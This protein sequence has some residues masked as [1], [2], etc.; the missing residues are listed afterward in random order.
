MKDVERIEDI[1]NIE[2]HIDKL[3]SLKAYVKGDNTQIW[4]Y[5][6]ACEPFITLEIISDEDT[7]LTMTKLSDLI[8]QP[9]IGYLTIS[10]Y[11]E[12]ECGYDNERPQETYSY[13]PHVKN[14]LKKLKL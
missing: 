10:Y 11:L 7:F 5:E 3:F 8:T 1:P 2:Y 6:Y 9:N 12:H 13:R 4:H 14:E